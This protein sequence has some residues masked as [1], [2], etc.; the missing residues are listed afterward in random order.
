MSKPKD[1]PVQNTKRTLDAAGFDA[2]NELL[3]KPTKLFWL[4]F[5]TGFTRGFSGVLGAAVAIVIIGFVVALFGGLPYI[6]DF[7]QALGKAAQAK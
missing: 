1:Q 2:I 4:N 3:H 6:G 7:L 5:R